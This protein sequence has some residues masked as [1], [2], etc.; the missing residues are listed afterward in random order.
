MKKALTEFRNIRVT[1]DG[2][3]VVISRAKVEVSKLFA[4]HSRKSL[5]AAEK[6]R[7]HKKM[8]YQVGYYDETGRWKNRAFSWAGTFK[9]F[10]SSA[11]NNVILPFPNALRDSLRARCCLITPGKRNCATENTVVFKLFRI[12]LPPVLNRAK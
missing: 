5:R 4:G 11:W 9:Y 10:A 6:F 8:Q 12:N 7:N 3:Q 2:Y 1:N